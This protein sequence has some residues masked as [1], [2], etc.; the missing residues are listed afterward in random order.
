MGYMDETVKTEAIIEPPKVRR[1]RILL[2][3]DL[4][5]YESLNKLAGYMGIPVAT[6]ITGILGSLEKVMG[7]LVQSLR[8]FQNARQ[9]ILVNALDR[10]IRDNLKGKK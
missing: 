6:L 3:V 2:T 7:Q 1:K 5:V 8:T 4:T 10:V 9:D